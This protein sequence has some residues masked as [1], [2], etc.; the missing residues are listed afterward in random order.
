M[1]K[2]THEPSG[3][4]AK[5]VS[6]LI[7]HCV[8]DRDSELCRRLAAGF[9]EGNWRSVQSVRRDS[10]DQGSQCWLHVEDLCPFEGGG[11]SQELITFR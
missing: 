3:W 6:G 10:H 8:G 4:A 9:A 7:F 2:I 11:V 5:F 1:L